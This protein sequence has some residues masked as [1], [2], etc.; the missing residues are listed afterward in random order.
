MRVIH[1][2]S[3][4]AIHS[5]L[6]GMTV[7]LVKK[8]KDRGIKFSVVKSLNAGVAIDVK[9]VSPE[10]ITVV[11]FKNDKWDS[12]QDI[13]KGN[14]QYVQA[15]KETVALAFQTSPFERDKI[16]YFELLNEAAPPSTA[17]WTNFGL[18]CIEIIKEANRRG[19]K[20]ALPAFNF[21]EPEW[22]EGQAFV[23]TGI[24][25][26]MADGG[27]LLTVHEGI[28]PDGM[29]KFSF[30]SIPGAP[31]VKRAGAYTWRYRYILDTLRKAGLFVNIFVSEFYSGGGY[32]I[33]NKDY[34]VNQFKVYDREIRRDPEV[35]GFAGFTIGA[36]A[37]WA[38]ADYSFIYDPYLLDYMATQTRV[39]NGEYFDVAD[40]S[41]YQGVKLPNGSWK[42][43]IDFK[44]AKD[45]DLAAVIIR[46]N[47]GLFRDPLAVE[48]IRRADAVGLPYGIYMY[49]RYGQPVADQV[50]L[51]L[52]IIREAVGGKLPPLGAFLDI[53]D[54]NVAAV[55]KYQIIQD[56][57][58]RLDAGFRSKTGI[59]SRSSYLNPLFTSVQQNSWA[60]RRYWEA[61]YGESVNNVPSVAEGWKS[62]KPAYCLW[63]KTSSAVWPGMTEKVFDLSQTYPG[64]PLWSIYPGGDVM[65]YV[66][67]DLG[68][69]SPATLT[70]VETHIKALMAD[71]KT[72]GDCFDYGQGNVV[73]HTM[74]DKRNQDV[75]NIF[76]RAF[77]TSY[78]AVVVR[79]GLSNAA[80][81]TGIASSPEI[82]QALYTGPAVEDMA[83]TP[84]EKDSL[85]AA[86]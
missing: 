57:L 26:L 58:S 83:L 32:K 54:E 20:V 18:F 77:G 5:I 30:S 80:G 75:L 81:T 45:N 38:G 39:P 22:D 10:T 70:K 50:S 47:D 12:A 40:I 68:N 64:Q 2:G 42:T 62:Q 56:A 79:A 28:S 23:G 51:C 33:E 13:E 48:H 31:H 73:K 74:R 15:A 17:G 85:I 78:W 7:P 49:L 86:L 24:F 52:A 41:Y 34:I 43:T 4:I 11:R 66:A 60:D 84:A 76:G 53:E 21:G 3:K 16:D 35:I 72:R 67:G 36:D 59:Y 82:R 44:V 27:H 71:V 55:G 1:N 61:E 9:A 8:A 19:I 6:P 25:K 65:I 29:E 37:S 46:T 14:F 69:P 63:Q